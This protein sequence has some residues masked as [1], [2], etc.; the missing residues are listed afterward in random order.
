M[1]TIKPS[2]KSVLRNE[3]LQLCQDDTDN[4]NS[5]STPRPRKPSERV[6]QIRNQAPLSHLNN[7]S[8]LECKS[9]IGIGIGSKCQKQLSLFFFTLP[10]LPSPSPCRV[11]A[12]VKKCFRVRKAAAARRRVCRM[13]HRLW[14][15]PVRGLSRSL[16]GDPIVN[17]SACREGAERAAGKAFR[18]DV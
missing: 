18:R 17:Q 1:L 11:A 15:P 6:C 3:A 7:P 13:L 4:P 12:A 5:G 10:A 16:E 8:K 14:T 2:P 9:W